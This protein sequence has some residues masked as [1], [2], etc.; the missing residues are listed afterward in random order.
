MS[1]ARPR[2]KLTN[3]LNDS[4]SLTRLGSDHIPFLSLRACREKELVRTNK[5]LH[6]ASHLGRSGDRGYA[7]VL[8]YRGC[9]E[10]WRKLHTV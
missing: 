3:R 9:F 1:A 5:T 6:T 7:Y 4:A 8:V 10:R 2:I